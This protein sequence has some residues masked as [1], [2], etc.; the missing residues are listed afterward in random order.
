MK[1]LLSTTVGALALM[2]YSSA[3]FS[4]FEGLSMM[5]MGDW[6]VDFSGNVNAFYTFVE[7]D[8]ASARHQ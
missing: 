2:A 5:R 1:K 8:G 7:C 4:A 3:A 6:E